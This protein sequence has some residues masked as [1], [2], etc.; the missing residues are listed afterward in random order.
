MVG[1]GDTEIET[2]KQTVY[3]A[4][5]AIPPRSNRGLGAFIFGLA[6]LALRTIVSRAA[7]PSPPES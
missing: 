7:S 5:A 3:V 6:A 2:L 1:I 4:V